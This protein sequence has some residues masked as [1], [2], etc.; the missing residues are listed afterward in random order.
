MSLNFN[1]G[2]ANVY[3]TP[4][5]WTDTFANRPPAN[6]V[7]IG[8]IFVASDTGNM[9][10]SD[11]TTWYSIGG[12]G[13]GS[14][15]L[16]SVLGFGNTATN[17]ITLNGS[18]GNGN[19]TADGI[20]SAGSGEVK[21]G[22]STS[23]Y[24]EL[25]SSTERKA[26]LGDGTTDIVKFRAYNQNEF[27][28]DY[29]GKVDGEIDTLVS[30]QPLHSPSVPWSITNYESRSTIDSK[31]AFGTCS[32][33]GFK[34]N[35]LITNASNVRLVAFRSETGVSEFVLT[36]LGEILINNSGISINLNDS[37]NSNQGIIEPQRFYTQN[38][39]TNQNSELINSSLQFYNGNTL[40]QGIYSMLGITYNDQSQLCTMQYSTTGLTL[41]GNALSKTFNLFFYQNLFG[42]YITA[43]YY[44]EDQ[45]GNG[46]KHL[47]YQEKNTI[48]VDLQ[49]T[50]NVFIMGDKTKTYFIYSNGGGGTIELDSANFVNGVI[51]YICIDHVTTGN[52]PVNTIGPL[53]PPPLWGASPIN[54]S[55]MYSVTYNSHLDAFAISHV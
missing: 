34:Y 27:V 3:K 53:F 32:N 16:A 51:V 13:G 43:D 12:G 1:N 44:F 31:L 4:G 40:D 28:I 24:V 9:Y 7:A 15:D 21:M 48:D 55:G 8:T 36:G 18:P 2:V 10:Q 6:V 41:L 39:T 30:T 38:T 49:V 25:R 52:L 17:N 54:K 5:M 33:I 45:T 50:P 35:P 14:Q 26:L 20:V 46:A 29:D 47:D 42:G 23:G 37:V 22:K 19:V 11:G